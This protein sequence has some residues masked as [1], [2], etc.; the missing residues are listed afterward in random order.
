MVRFK[1]R[2]LLVEFLFP[3]SQPTSASASLSSSSPDSFVPVESSPRPSKRTK[4]THTKSGLSSDES[5]DEDGEEEETTVEEDLLFPALNVLPLLLPPPP[6]SK[7]GKRRALDEK[8]IFLGIKNSVIQ[9]FGDD[10]WGRVSGGTNVKYYCPQTNLCIIRC[11]RD[12]Y[13]TV[14][15]ALSMLGPINSER[16]VAR[17]IRCSGTIKK[18]QQATT[19]YN[20][21]LV[22]SIL[23]ST[24]PLTSSSGSKNDTS[25]KVGEGEKNDPV[26][27]PHPGETGWKTW[28]EK[29]NTAVDNLVD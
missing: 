5:Q 4:T 17:V 28:L 13:R 6:N 16:V 3:T 22:S 29:E 23:A 14:W 12:H 24:S 15:A 10:G 21:L 11:A 1:N 26:V 19:T 9:I 8:S 27:L 20:R 18:I 25:S 2:W 7:T